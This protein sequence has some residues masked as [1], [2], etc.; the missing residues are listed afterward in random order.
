MCIRIKLIPSAPVRRTGLYK[1]RQPHPLPLAISAN[2][3]E[4]IQHGSRIGYQNDLALA[5]TTA[6]ESRLVAVIQIG[7]GFPSMLEVAATGRVRNG[8][9]TPKIA[10]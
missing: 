7:N 8:V 2:S 4:P 6:L 10:R 5:T 3:T 1:R 9:A